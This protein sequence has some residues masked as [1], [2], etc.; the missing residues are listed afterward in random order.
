[1]TKD[2]SQCGRL[3]SLTRQTPWAFNLF[4][5][6]VNDELVLRACLCCCVFRPV[7]GAVLAVVASVLSVAVDAAGG[8]SVSVLQN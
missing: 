1:M 3:V 5:E 8:E 4:L 2:Q 7:E 6:Q